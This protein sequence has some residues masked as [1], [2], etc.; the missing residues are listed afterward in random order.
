[1]SVDPNPASGSA[2]AEDDLDDGWAE[3]AEAVA[4]E[5]EFSAEDK[6]K[7]RVMQAHNSHKN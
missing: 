6:E 5:K 2:V 1:M 3:A 7:L 4:K